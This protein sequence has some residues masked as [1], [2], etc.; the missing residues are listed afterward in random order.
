M[1]DVYI[2]RPPPPFLPYYGSTTDTMSRRRANHRSHYRRWKEGSHTTKCSYF[3]LFDAAG[4]DNCIVESVESNI[5]VEQ[6]KWRERYWVENNPCVNI[7]K[8][9]VA[10]HERE[11]LALVYKKKHRLKTK[12]C[13]EENVNTRTTDTSRAPVGQRY[14]RPHSTLTCSPRNT[15]SNLSR[16]TMLNGVLF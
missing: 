14:C 1:P 16:P 2:V 8:P 15:K 9:I 4:I 5:P 11:T 10:E 12:G 3:D 6:L 13:P 7:R